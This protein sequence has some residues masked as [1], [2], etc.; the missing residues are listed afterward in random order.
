[1][2]AGVP[3]VVADTTALPW[4][5]GDAGLKFRPGDVGQLAGELARVIDQPAAHETLAAAGRV[6]A[7]RFTWDRSAVELAAGYRAAA[8]MGE[9]RRT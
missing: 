4:V 8:S 6:R 5:V 3:V 7:A 2:A 9:N 1:M